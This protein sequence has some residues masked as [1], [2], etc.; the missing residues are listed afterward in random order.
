MISKGIK[1]PNNDT[2]LEP[3]LLFLRE[4]GIFDHLRLDGHDRETLEA[5]PDVTIEFALGLDPADSQRRF[6]T[7]T[8]LALIVCENVQYNVMSCDEQGNVQKPGSLVMT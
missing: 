2:Y 1:G 3:C 6:D 8:P 7:H 4:H 5:Q